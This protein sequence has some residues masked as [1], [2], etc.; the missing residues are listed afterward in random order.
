MAPLISKY[1]PL[2]MVSILHK[3]CLHWSFPCPTVILDG[4]FSPIDS[5]Q[6]PTWLCCAL[7][8]NHLHD[9]LQEQSIIWLLQPLKHVGITSHNLRSLHEFSEQSWLPYSLVE[10]KEA[11]RTF[12]IFN[13]L[14]SL[15][16]KVSDL[17]PSKDVLDI[18]FTHHLW[19][20]VNNPT[21]KAVILL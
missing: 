8:S 19:H 9:L 1:P 4:L 5:P 21:F 3:L 20:E 6:K 16:F 14:A 2:L 15:A 10:A 7:N 11:R 12:L 17:K 18:M 13:L